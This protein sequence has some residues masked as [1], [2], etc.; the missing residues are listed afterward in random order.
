L[1]KRAIDLILCFDRVDEKHNR[2]IISQIFTAFKGDDALDKV[3]EV[4]EHFHKKWE[5]YGKKEGDD[6]LF[7]A[8]LVD[9]VSQ[10]GAESAVKK[11]YSSIFEVPCY[12]N[13]NTEST[14]P[15]VSAIHELSIY[16]A[17]RGAADEIKRVAKEILTMMYDMGAY[18]D[19]D[20]TIDRIDAKGGLQNTTIKKELE[21]LKANIEKQDIRKQYNALDAEA[22][23][24][25]KSSGISA[26]EIKNLKKDEEKFEKAYQKCIEDIKA[27]PVDDSRLNKQRE[28]AQKIERS[29]EI[30]KGNKIRIE[31][32][33]YCIGQ[34]QTIR[35]QHYFV[36]ESRKALRSSPL[37]SKKPGFTGSEEDLSEQLSRQVSNPGFSMDEYK[38]EYLL[39]PTKTGHN[40]TEMFDLRC[41]VEEQEEQT[42]VYADVRPEF[43]LMN[44]QEGGYTAEL[45]TRRKR[46][47]SGVSGEL[48]AEK[49]PNPSWTERSN[50]APESPFSAKS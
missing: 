42:E 7:P 18:D 36:K 20:K 27:K 33:E 35:E 8:I 44:P 30:I 49:K 47:G 41:V 40:L 13:K 17:E 11:E 23:S 10:K 12:K 28:R 29:L 25:L 2:S 9:I 19:L 38:E 34:L 26:S 14:I 5:S 6:A 3:Q 37:A 24:L 31:F 43:Q 45:G 21:A 22:T 1:V 39:S 32:V 50:A 16:C 48:P 4:F 46:K 15:I